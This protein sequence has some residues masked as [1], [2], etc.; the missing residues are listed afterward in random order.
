MGQ[1]P[2]K[3]LKTAYYSDQVMHQNVVDGAD[4]SFRK[5]NRILCILGDHILLPERQP[6]L[7]GWLPSKESTRRTAL[8][9][10]RKFD[11]QHDRQAD[12]VKYHE[13]YHV[14]VITH[15]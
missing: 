3:V 13:V 9:R 11:V 4:L 12:N 7:L 1:S 10:H 6:R 14:S 8:F 5:A 2:S 15:T